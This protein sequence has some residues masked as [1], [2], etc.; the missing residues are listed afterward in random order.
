MTQDEMKQQV[1]EA[2]LDYI[3]PRLEND[4][5]IGIGTG[6]TANYFID[7]IAAIKGQINATVAS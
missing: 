6:S 5:V 7:A 4:S 1:A 2:A 3:R